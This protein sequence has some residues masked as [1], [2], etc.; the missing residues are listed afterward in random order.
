MTYVG[1]LVLSLVIDRNKLSSG[2]DGCL[3]SDVLFPVWRRLGLLRPE[4]NSICV[5]VRRD[6]KKQR[7]TKI[8]ESSEQVNLTLEE[9]V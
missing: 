4:K 3:T 5:A 6:H 2:V 1:G 8:A 9:P 7:R